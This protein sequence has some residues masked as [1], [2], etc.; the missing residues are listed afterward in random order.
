MFRKTANFSPKT[1]KCKLVCLCGDFN[2]PDI[3][4]EDKSVIA[5]GNLVSTSENLIEIVN[6]AGLTQMNSSPTREKSSWICT[7]Q[8]I[9]PWFDR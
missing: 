3:S 7:L 9:P 8:T 4:W 2:L 5:D 1:S 6:E